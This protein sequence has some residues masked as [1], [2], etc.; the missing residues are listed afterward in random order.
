MSA[1]KPH[2]AR[3]GYMRL[4]ALDIRHD[5]IKLEQAI[6]EVI[7]EAIERT[8]DAG[9]EMIGRPTATVFEG[10]GFI[11]DDPSIRDGL[12][13]TGAVVGVFIEIQLE[14]PTVVRADT[15]ETVIVAQ[16]HEEHPDDKSTKPY[17]DKFDYP[18]TE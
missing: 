14:K 4:F 11:R 12:L 1:S 3:I 18:P 2:R 15:E 9:L 10:E 17:D 8:H 16:T 7:E 6:K 5:P 13:S